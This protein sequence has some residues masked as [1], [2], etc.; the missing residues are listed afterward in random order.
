MKT[1]LVNLPW[2]KEGRLGVRAGS[3]WPFISKPSEDGRLL[4][5]P[6]PF[7]LAYS[8]ALLKKE[9]KSVQLIDAIAE[10]ISE[11]ACIERLKEFD[12]GLVLIE[13]STPTFKS[14]KRIAEVIR[15]GMEDVKIGLCGAHAGEFAAEI[16]RENH[17]IDFVVVGEYEQ[18]VVGLV[19]A[20]ERRC[21][22]EDVDG[23]AYRAGD[24][25][26]VSDRRGCIEDLDALP[27]P[28]RSAP[29]IYQYKDGFAGLPCPSAQMLASRGC[30]F[31][32]SFCL[33]P[34][35]L[36]KGNGYRK[37]NFLDVVDE[38]EFLI[39]QFN[40]KSIYFDDEVFN[41]DREYAANICEEI[42][43]RGL[44]VPWA[45]MTRVD[46]MDEELLKL[47]SRA[48]VYALKYGIESADENIRQ[49]CQKSLS[50][51]KARS[52]IKASKQLGIKVH[53]T[54]CVGLPGETK[55]TVQTTIDFAK[56]LA[57][58]SLQFTFAVPFPGTAYFN[59][60]AEKG[61]LVSNNWD[62]YHGNGKCVVRTRDLSID[63]LEIIKASLNNT[64]KDQCGCQS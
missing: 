59:D 63:D 54:F 55:Q 8:A 20:L 50:L 9:G 64:F 18:A 36:Y 58:D 14:D 57:P 23:L 51:E 25:I 15:Q 11:C 38:M 26:M 37:R 32:C 16:L 60:A 46:L 49:L 6:F 45:A 33:L 3:R 1:A 29:L 61:W 4:Y 21:G 48:G 12:P 39:R 62:D 43:K 35:T 53:L 27:W 7:F 19:N 24:Q 28:E 40:I 17:S 31:N 10:G 44:E 41:C 2:L 34:Q 13:T 42:I 56:S 5:I 22:L 52:V 47:M 30:P